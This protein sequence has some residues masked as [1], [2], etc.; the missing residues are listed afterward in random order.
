MSGAPA[1]AAWSDILTAKFLGNT[2]LQWV[3]L[4]GIILGSLVVGRVASFLLQKQAQ[5]LEAKEKLAALAMLLASAQKPSGLLILAGGLYLATGSGMLTLADETLRF[6]GQVCQALAVLSAGWFIYRL[7]DLV[8]HVLRRWT[9]R[10]DS[11]LDNQLVPLIRKSLRVF[12]VIVAALFIAQNVFQWDIGALVAGLG[13]GGLAFALAAKDMLANLFG[14]VT[15]FADRPFQMG[16]RIRVKGYDG[17]VE[18]VGFRSTR[19]RTLEG[20]LVTLPN[21]VIADEPV[22]NVSRRP[23]IRRVL[24][25]TVT[26]DTSPAKL[27]RALDILGQMLEVRRARFAPDQPPRVFFS[28]FNADSLNLAVYYWFA[29]PDWWEFQAFNHEFNLELLKRY[30]EEGIEFAFPTRTLYL[31][32]GSPLRA[33][34]SRGDDG[35]QL[36]G[37]F[38]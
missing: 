11:A 1:L 25:V 16:D 34:L 20:H 15:I 6:W 8:E 5:R 35:W 3:G 30:N 10:T 14:S 4:L 33:E 36:R 13:I 29:P 27:R 24:N 21:S 19:V 9:S 12:V 32:Q 26:Y 23:Y 7:V 2:P 22:E 18:E 38:T 31:K 17:T 28:D 37:P